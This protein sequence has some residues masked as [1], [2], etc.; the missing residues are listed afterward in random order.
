MAWGSPITDPDTIA[1]K[2]IQKQLDKL[3]EAKL[4]KASK[5]EFLSLSKRMDELL[6]KQEIYW[7]QWS[8]INWLKHGDRNTKFFH[9][10][11]SQRRRKNYIRGI[12]TSQ[13]QWVENLEEVVE[14]ASDYFDNLF[15]ARLGDQIKE[16][17]DAVESM[18]T[19]DMREFLSS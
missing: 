17:L 1:I 3:N 11:A 19:D 12:R 9:A 14:V 16:C 13:G 8:R 5:A 7:A 2:E 6:Q 18:V 10:K 4:T 15:H